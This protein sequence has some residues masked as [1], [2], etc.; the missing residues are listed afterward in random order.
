MKTKA[1]RILLS[2]CLILFCAV[3]AHSRAGGAGGSHSGGGG[4]FGGGGYSGGSGGGGGGA[5]VWFFLMPW[6]VKILIVLG[7]IAFVIYGYI[8]RRDSGGTDLVSGSSAGPKGTPQPTSPD[9]LAANQGFTEE[10]FKQ[11]VNTAFMAIQE[12]W[13]KKDLS[14]VRK[15]ITDGV[16]QRFNTQFVMMNML[17]QTN[18]LSNIN[19]KQIRIESTSQEGAYSIITASVFFQVDDTFMCKKA[20]EFNE[21]FMGDE[22]TEYWTFIKN[23]R[24]RK[25]SLPL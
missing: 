23:I 13:M 18:I 21:K 9:F 22:A 10:G 7:I 5:L 16:Y 15:W 17:E 2:A 6:P 24:C 25:G 11:K 12:A 1:T 4:G 20:P 19:I 14:K 3:E 8:K